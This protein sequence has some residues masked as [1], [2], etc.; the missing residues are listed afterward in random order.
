MAI[1]SVVK[2]MYVSVMS[3]LSGF[4]FWCHFNWDTVRLCVNCKVRDVCL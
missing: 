4:E 2:M 3:Y 1:I